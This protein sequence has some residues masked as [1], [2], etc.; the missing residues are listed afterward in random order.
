MLFA[1]DALQDQSYYPNAPYKL[2]AADAVHQI[3]QQ[4]QAGLKMLLQIY[5]QQVRD[6]ATGMVKRGVSISGARDGVVR[7]SSFYDN[8]ILWKTLQL[9]DRLGIQQTPADQLTALRNNIVKTYWDNDEGHFKDDLSTR[10]ASQNYSSD[11]LVTIPTDFLNAA[12]PADQSYLERSRDFIR[13]QGIASPFP[14]KYEAQSMT[15]H[16][17]W[18]VRFFLPSYGGDVVW[19][20]WGCQYIAMLNG[21]YAATH[22]AA[23]DQ[24]A[25]ADIAIYA[26]KIV[27]NHGFPETFDSSGKFL[28]TGIYKSILRNGWIVDFEA[29]S[30]QNKQLP[31]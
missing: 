11:W 13:A 19:S 24:E 4:R 16:I 10:P 17:P 2:E 7:D 27:E 23:Y 28:R 1:L 22:S 14:I 3:L 29:V 21:L 15:D 20:Y 9:A 30:I 6:P 25:S 12:N 26:N 5:E 18:A 8:V 31:R